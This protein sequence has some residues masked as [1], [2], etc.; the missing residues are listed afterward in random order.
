MSGAEMRLSSSLRV[1]YLNL[2]T[3]RITRKFPCLA[4][5]ALCGVPFRSAEWSFKLNGALPADSSAPCSA[6]VFISDNRSQGQRKPETTSFRGVGDG[7]RIVGSEVQYAARTVLKI[8]LQRAKFALV[9]SR[10]SIPPVTSAVSFRPALISSTNART[11]D[12]RG[13]TS[14]HLRRK[15]PYHF[16]LDNPVEFSFEHAPSP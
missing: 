5:S 6:V 15:M 13:E 3:H 2:A 16:P 1:G 4:T 10:A 11:T 8:P 9:S 12:D 7:L 14:W